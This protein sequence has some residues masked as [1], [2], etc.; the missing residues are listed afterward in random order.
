MRQEARAK[1]RQT[2]ILVL[3][4]LVAFMVALDATVVATAL[5][6]IRRD[7]GVSI[8]ELGW[9]VNAYTLSYAVLLIPATAL[10]DRLG[11]RR[12]LVIGL[13]LFVA[14][15]AACALSRDASW[16]IAARAV[17]GSGEA[18]VF[19]LALTQLSMAFPPEQRGRA[20]GIF[21]GVVGL[22]L[23]AGPTL[24]GAIVEGLAWQWI[25]WLN[26]PIGLVVIV[27]VLSR[28]PESFGP[29]TTLD[30]GGILSISGAALGFTWGLTLGNGA[31][32]GSPLV[33]G[34]LLAGVLFV[35]VFVIWEQHT[36]TPMV[37]MHF[38][39][40]RGFSAGNTANFLL[41]ASLTG[42]VFLLAQ[43]LQTVLG[44]RPLDAG[45]RLLPLTGT[46]FIISPIAGTLVN[47]V[48]ERALTVGGLLLETIGITWIA[49]IAGHGHAYYGL[50]AP[51]I[52]TGCGVS[53]TLPAM[54]NAIVSAVAP[55]EIGK[56]SGTL[57]MF[58]QFGGAFGVALL[59]AVFAGA[60]GFGSAQTFSNGFALALGV[61]AVLSLLGAFAGLVLPGRSH[62][63]LTQAQNRKHEA[64]DTQQRSL[65]L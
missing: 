16:L 22:A 15:S 46:L 24:G 11:R 53:M 35:V 49:L 48:G 60:G 27:L 33:V 62:G 2:W 3:A 9:I 58:R 51:L 56:A 61:A 43:F 52:I 39:R 5:T 44:Y 47:R 64:D 28:I 42:V 54:Q 36:R 30:I 37:P 63:A 40:L 17:Q 32:W 19:P 8:E 7:L 55:N 25:F 26:V 13:G 29:R 65:R 21:S 10:G 14:A 50:I 45:L 38:F 59:A 12:M 6:T 57:S 23:I 1:A 18:L 20:M 31:G 4:S 41:N 34:P